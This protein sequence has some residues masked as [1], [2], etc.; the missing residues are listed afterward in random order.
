MTKYEN[1]LNLN[2][3]GTGGYLIFDLKGALE[4][5]R[6]RPVAEEKEKENKDESKKTRKKGQNVVTK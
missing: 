5:Q 1:Y 2:V 4:T 6:K 3:L